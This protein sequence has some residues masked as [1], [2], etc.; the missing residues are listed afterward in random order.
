LATL[1]VPVAPLAAEVPVLVAMDPLS[2]AFVTPEYSAATAA[3]GEV[4]TIVIVEVTVMPVK[5]FPIKIVMYVPLAPVRN[6]CT[7]LATE[8]LSIYI[9][10]LLVPATMTI[11]FPAVG[12]EENVTASEE[13]LLDIAVVD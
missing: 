9:G 10:E 2:R 4:P 7:Q 6:T 11:I 5:T 1:V 13:A 8:E 3:M 12:V